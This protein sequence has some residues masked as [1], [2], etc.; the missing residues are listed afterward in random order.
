MRRPECLR[1]P[2]R[3]SP[4]SV[5][6][7]LGCRS[8]ICRI[9]Y[10]QNS[11]PAATKTAAASWDSCNGAL[12]A[13]L[14]PLLPDRCSRRD[15]SRLRCCWCD[16]C[17]P[18]DRLVSI[19]RVDWALSARRTHAA[20][21]AGVRYSDQTA[22]WPH[23]G[24]VSRTLPVTVLQASTP[25]SSHELFCMTMLQPC[26]G[27][28]QMFPQARSITV[29]FANT[30]SLTLGICLKLRVT[31]QLTHTSFPT[32]SLDSGAVAMEARS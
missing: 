4:S 14:A 17:R 8:S 23:A 13:P 19:A 15:P 5:G 11:S 32:Q 24:A 21:S 7:A 27:P 18:R 2:L 12:F 3:Q 28:R 25:R 31:P 9:M 29:G 16:S 10:T 1:W 20:V 30:Y 22:S 6:S 26:M